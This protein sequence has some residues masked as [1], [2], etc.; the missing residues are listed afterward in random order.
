[1]VAMCAGKLVRMLKK[2]LNRDQRPSRRHAQ[3]PASP[4]RRNVYDNAACRQ[5][6]TGQQTASHIRDDDDDVRSPSTSL[7]TSS[8]SH[9]DVS[10]SSQ[11][12]PQ[13]RHH[14]SDQD[15][16]IKSRLRLSSR[17]LY[18]PCEACA[19]LSYQELSSSPRGRLEFCRTCRQP[20]YSMTSEDP[21]QLVRTFAFFICCW[22]VA[23]LRVWWRV[24]G[25]RVWCR[26]VRETNFSSAV[27]KRDLINLNEIYMRNC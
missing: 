3:S 4:R 1:M 12:T 10:H 25:L 26:G 22:R 6:Q 8:A 20:L 27:T 19:R 2:C 14:R 16:T 11:P 15:V 23:G 24:A 17:D 13:R 5:Q 18:T 9:D 7:R 21:K